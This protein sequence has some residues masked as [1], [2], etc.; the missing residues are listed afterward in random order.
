MNLRRLFLNITFLWLISAPLALANQ[1]HVQR[2]K[3]ARSAYFSKDYATSMEHLSML[4]E[5][6][7]PSDI[8][9]Y[10]FFYYALAAYHSDEK[11]IAIDTFTSLLSRFSDWDKIEEVWYWLGQIQFEQGNYV[12]GLAFLSRIKNNGLVKVVENLKT[13]YFQQVSYV[14]TLQSLLR[15]YPADRT[16]AQVLFERLAQ[17]PLIRRDTE[18]LDT[19][20][21]RFNLVLKERDLLRG[22]SSVKKDHYDV[23][24]FLPFFAH[25]MDYSKQSEHLFVINL[26]QGIQAAVAELEE[27]GIKINIHAY[28]TKRDPAVTAAILE[29]EKVRKLDLIIGPLYPATTPLVTAFANTHKINLFN[30]LSENANVVGHNPFTFL[31]RPSLETQARSAADFTFQN[32]N[33]DLRVGI[34]YSALKE[35][36]MQAHLYKQYIERKMGK[37]VDM[38]LSITPNEAPSFLNKL[39]LSIEKDDELE[40]EE[41][42]AEIAMLE[43]EKL[44]DTLAK[45][46]HIYVVSADEL[47]AANVLSAVE[48][49]GLKPCIIGHEQWLNHSAVLAQMQRLGVFLIAPNFI[50]YEKEN[51]HTFRTHFYKQSGAYPDLSAFKGYE[52]MSFLGRMLAYHGVYF[53]KYWSN[54]VYPGAIFEGISYGNHHDNQQVPIIQLRQDGFFMCH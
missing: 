54:K 8:T 38:M 46:T 20:A 42:D 23:G 4:M 50:D 48:I 1:Q 53:Q 40:E 41:I 35:E 27:E 12:D 16:I 17:Q 6:E 49:L 22:L 13:H 52:M 28:D 44:E 34:I 33:E 29:D 14:D 19:L 9:P 26:Y 47:I 32:M 10:A 39:R 31:F 21:H 43:E 45:L 11:E 15:L 2:Y 30:P 5:E 25:E 7:I 3:T 51:V 18:L 37:E 36:S 24:V